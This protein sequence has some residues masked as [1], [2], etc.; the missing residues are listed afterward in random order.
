MQQKPLLSVLSICYNCSSFI[1]KSYNN[2]STQTFSDWEWIFVDD[3]SSDDS[4]QIVRSIHDSRINFIALPRNTGRGFAR[5]TGIM[6]ST[7]DYISIWDLDDLYSADRL[8]QSAASLQ[9][10]YDYC[11]QDVYITSTPFNKEA[12]LPLIPNKFR[13]QK[14]IHT[15]LSFNKTR[16]PALPYQVLA[17]TGGI[18]E[19]HYILFYLALFAKGVLLKSS[20]YYFQ[21]REVYLQKTVH[22][23]YGRLLCL[24]RLFFDEKLPF[25]IRSTI[26]PLEATFSL[27]SIMLSKSLTKF[28][29]LLGIKPSPQLL[30]KPGRFFR[31]LFN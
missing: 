16:V 10:G 5:N 15:T 23:H 12:S 20:S 11:Y 13:L 17:T 18:G 31:K 30:L 21:T 19:D 29:L 9:A 27:G 3:G 25:G 24:L 22:S 26:I 4:V 1:L 14:P 7:T 28:S 8:G 6:A 2:L